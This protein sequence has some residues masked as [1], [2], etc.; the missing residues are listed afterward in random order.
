[1]TSRTA[2]PA[3]RPVGRPRDPAL[4]VAILDAALE[5]LCEGGLD[6]CALDEVARRAGVGKATI[7]R[8]WRSK[9]DLVRDAFGSTEPDLVPED[10]GALT[11]DSGALLHA[12][13]GALASPRARAWRR[14]VPALGPAAPLQADL[15]AG[16][17]GD[18]P[19]A[20]WAVVDRAETRGD[21]PAGAFPVLA[22]EAAGAVL[23]A[24]WLTGA[25]PAEVA[26]A[27]V[28]E[29]LAAVVAPNLAR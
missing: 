29:L 19:A 20:V 23:V 16:P 21:V 4:D 28:A 11:A 25:D 26:D 12:L 9:D 2:P 5:L 7:Y 8:R 10:G 15:P 14:T 13:A 6:A 18:W 3:P 24:R 1:M 17:V 22:L 27:L